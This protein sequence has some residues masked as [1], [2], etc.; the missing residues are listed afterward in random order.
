MIFCEK[1]IC[2]VKLKIN[3]YKIKILVERGLIIEKAP[4]SIGPDIV[5]THNKFPLWF[6][7]HLDIKGVF[8]TY[9]KNMERKKVL[10]I[11]VPLF[12]F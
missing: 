11:F 5:C 8:G 10:K 2:L 3:I 12:G 4:R 1:I 9:E 6:A 7:H